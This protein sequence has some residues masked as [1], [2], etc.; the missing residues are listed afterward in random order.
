[1]IKKIL[2]KGAGFSGMALCWYLLSLP[3][4]LEITLFSK[5]VPASKVSAGILHKYMGP[6]GKLNALAL[7]GEQETFELLKVANEHA[8]H[9][10]ILSK[11]LIRIAITDEQK[12][13]F[14]KCSIDY[15]EVKW[16]ENCQNLD[17]HTVMAPGIFINSGLTIDTE[18]YL[19]ALLIACIDKGLTVTLTDSED[20]YDHVIEAMGAYTSSVP[21]HQVKGQ[22]LELS[23]PKHLPPL[24]YPLISQH[25]LA[26]AR[27]PKTVIIGATF[28][29]SFKSVDP[30]P[31]FAISALYSKAIELYPELAG[32]EI[33][34]VKSGLRATTPSRL[35]FT[36]ILNP[37]L[38]VL[39]GLGS[40][41]L[42]YHAHFAKLLVKDLSTMLFVE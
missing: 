8:K 21:V 34:S 32:V 17:P 10:I 7:E 3:Q 29:H 30:D 27:D 6:R 18:A 28:E 39:A 37:K 31:E 36:K 2:V 4:D 22:L 24:P 40:K 25:Y 38:S 35:P 42:L 23:W 11:G 5:G 33:L 20:I 15:A 14:K 16:I 13:A 9:P 41:G 19:E 1:M 12:V 26:R